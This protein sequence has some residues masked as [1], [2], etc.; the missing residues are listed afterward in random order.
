MTANPI[1][2]ERIAELKALG[3]E[4]EDLE[5]EWGDLGK[6][7]YRWNHTKSG[8]FQD[9]ETSDSEAEAWVECSNF[10]TGSPQPKHDPA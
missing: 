1:T 2:P 6:G 5:Q 7:Q 10:E 4:V 9:W 3:Y 8:D